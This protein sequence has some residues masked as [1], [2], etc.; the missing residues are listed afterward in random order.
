MEGMDKKKAGA[1]WKRQRSGWLLLAGAAVIAAGAAG[2]Y[3]NQS[4]PVS[5]GTA[6]RKLPIYSVETED[7]VVSLTFDSAWGSEDLAEILNILAE[8]RVK[9]SFFVTGEFVQNYP[10]E[11]KQIDLAGHDLGNHGDGHLHMTELDAEECAKEVEGAHTKVKNLTGQDMELFRPPY[12][13]YNDTVIGAA[14][15]LGYYSIQWD[16]DSLD[17]KDYGVKDIVRR[18][19]NHEKLRNGSIILL[20]SGTAYTAQALPELIQGLQEAGYQLVPVSQLIIRENYTIDF[21][22]RQRGKE[23]QEY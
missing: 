16:V 5:R 21:E 9:A 11:V 23:E 14:E 18:V 15:E 10:E 2:I 22:G 8:Y 4:A 17:W 1:E 13:D 7:K 3:L 20:H 19:V 12:G 6:E